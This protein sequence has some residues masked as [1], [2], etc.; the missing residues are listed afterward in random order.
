M[1]KQRRIELT[2]ILERIEKAKGELESIRDDLDSLKSEEEEYRDNMPE[3][4][5]NGEKGERANAA[6]DAMQE[7]YDALDGATEQCGEAV[8][9]IET[10]SE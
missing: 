2:R 9:G 1:N 8:T 4:V 6:C 10:A 3:S 7:A 5:Q